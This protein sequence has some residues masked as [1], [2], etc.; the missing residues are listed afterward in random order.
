[1][2]AHTSFPASDFFA[3]MRQRQWA[4]A[5]P[6]AM[7]CRA[8]IDETHDVK[9]FVF[10]AAS[11]CMFC[12]NAGQY[13]VL[14]LA[15]DGVVVARSYSVSSPP[16]RPLDLHITVKRTPGGLV[17]NW[18]H[19]NLRAGDEIKIEGPRGSFKLDGLPG[20]KPLFLAG[21]SGIT[22]LMSM[23]RTLTDRA[24]DLDLCL[25][26]SA[27]SPRDLI[28]RSELD[29]LAARFRNLS[30]TCVCSRADPS[31]AGPTGRM[32]GPLLL[33]LVPD[34]RE[35]TVYACGPEQY[36]KAL[37]DGLGQAG[38]DP[39]GYHEESFGGALG[40]AAPDVAS[41]VS[42]SV[43]F[44]RSGLE[45]RCAPGETLLEAAR[46]CGVYVPTGCQQG[47]CGACRIAKLSGEVAMQDLGGL[48][49]E[50][51]SAGFVLACCSR[52]Q[53][54]VLLDL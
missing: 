14:H 50:E 36:M 4:D 52:A 17:S 9:T 49:S 33:R 11:D 25:I 45:H 8:V 24:S 6:Q 51:K 34:L 20:E 32:D 41:A 42:S 31:W 44:A 43:H 12:F 37:R 47:I 18:I 5:S 10:S 16:T 26:Y 38:V 39:R 22:P 29:A 27:R 1:M 15:I 2:N 3:P 54:S 53:G 46:N 30:V 48:T 13:V 40:G 35:R 21:G 19:E 7:L 28:F 23:L